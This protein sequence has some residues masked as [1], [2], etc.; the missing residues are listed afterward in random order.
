MWDISRTIKNLV[1]DK[2]IFAT[3]L[4]IKDNMRMI[5]SKDKEN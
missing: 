2:K 1:K 5:C 4:N 3:E